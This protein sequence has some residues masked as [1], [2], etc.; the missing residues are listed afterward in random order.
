M[1]FFGWFLRP[2]NFE[3][4]ELIRNPHPL[5]ITFRIA[6]VMGVGNFQL[7]LGV[8]SNLSIFFGMFFFWDVCSLCKPS[9][10]SIYLYLYVLFVKPLAYTE[11]PGLKIWPF[12]HLLTSFPPLGPEKHVENQPNFICQRCAV[13]PYQ[14]NGEDPRPYYE[15]LGGIP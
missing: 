3:G 1:C 2:S 8:A 9:R 6:S 4:S 5:S 12:H 14:G 10:L 11:A 7:D 13:W 15:M